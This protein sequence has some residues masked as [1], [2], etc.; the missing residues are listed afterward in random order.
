MAVILIFLTATIINW[1]PVFTRPEAVDI[2][3]NSWRFLQQTGA[4][5]IFGY[6]IMENHLHL[7]ARS[8]NLSDN[9][10]RFKANTTKEILVI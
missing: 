10:R 9:I 6:V 1:L 2:V 7:V 3:L 4:F 5:E 8:P